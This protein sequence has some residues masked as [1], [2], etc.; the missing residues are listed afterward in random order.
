MNPFRIMIVE[1]HPNHVDQIKKC[2]IDL[3][4][5]V[6]G[7]AQS[8]QEAKQLYVRVQ[9]DI[10][11]VD[12]HLKKCLSGIK[13]VE[14]IRDQP[15][16]GP[17]IYLFSQLNSRAISLSN[18]TFPAGYLEK[19]VRKEVLNA[20]IELAMQ[21]HKRPPQTIM[22]SE[23]RDKHVIA[24]D[25]ILFLEADHI[26]VQVNMAQG[27]KII[28][29][30]SLSDL[31]EKLPAE[32]FIKTHRSYVVNLDKVSSC[33]QQYVY[34]QSRAIPL[35]RSRRKAVLCRLIKEGASGMRARG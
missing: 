7:I 35:S 2:S 8:C 22:V 31:L 13:F 34:I 17:F 32:Q 6:V 15:Q 29:R 14:F 25:D 30:G 33:K 28:H 3:G 11:L 16:H 18:K 26:Y 12:I 5:Q 19:P 20:T 10:T 4:Y 1:D 24:I 23:G 21:Q 27:K 9:P